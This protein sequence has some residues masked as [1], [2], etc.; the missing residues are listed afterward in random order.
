MTAGIDP[1]PVLSSYLGVMLA[2]AMFLALGLLVSSL[3]RSQMVA[4]LVSLVLGLL[5]IVVGFWRPDL[6]TGGLP[7][8]ILAYISVPLHFRSDF[9]RGIIDTGHVVLYGSV[10][11]FCLF[12]T[13]RSLESRR[14]R[15]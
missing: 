7:Y 9:T 8:R 13:V 12:L 14:W 10:A 5:F 4:A 1:R 6:D 11:V 2:G 3:V 15:A